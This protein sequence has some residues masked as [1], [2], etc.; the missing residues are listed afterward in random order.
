MLLNCGVGED[1][2]E[3][4]GLQGDQTSI[5]KEISP[6]IH[7]TAW[8]WTET[9]I[10]WP[11]DVKNWLTGK[12]SDAEKDWRQEEKGTTEEE[13]VGWH[14]RLDGHKFEQAMGVGDRQRSLAC[15][16]PWGRRESHRTEWLNWPEDRDKSFP[17]KESACHAGNL[18][19]IPRS[20]RSPGEGNGNP[21]Q[22]SCLE[23][24][25][26]KGAWWA[27]V[28]GVAKSRTRLSD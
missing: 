7:W 14:H 26:D 8:C 2:W 9:P 12:N 4:L 28:H 3:S 5:L 11:P 20:G 10:L 18:V 17:G 15:C 6:N 13:I 24:P 19:S 23:N 25:M 1:S 21:L 16:S 22:Y 27:T